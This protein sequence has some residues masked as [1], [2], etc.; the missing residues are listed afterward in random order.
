MRVKLGIPH[1]EYADVELRFACLKRRI[2]R[3]ESIEKLLDI[4]FDLDNFHDDND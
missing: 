1:R 2:K 4:D 3:E